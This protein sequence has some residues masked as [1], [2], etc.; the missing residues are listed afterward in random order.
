MAFGLL[1]SAVMNICFGM[2]GSFILLIL[3]WT[4]NG[5]FQGIG[6][7]PCGRS[8]AH[9]YTS[10]ERGVKTSIWNSSTSIGAG[11]VAVLCGNLVEYGW[12]LCF[13]VPAA[14]AIV[15]AVFVWQRL[16]D[17]PQSLGLPSIEEYGREEPVPT[18]AAET[19]QV[20][21]ESA[22]S[23]RRFL[24]H[25]VFLNP[26]MWAVS[27]ANFFLYVVRYAI[28]DWSPTFLQEMRE[29]PIAKGGYWVAVGFEGA[30]VLGMLVGGWMCDR[31]F[32]GRAGRACFFAM[33]ICAL[34]ILLFWRLPAPYAQSIWANCLLAGGIGFFCYSAQM[35]VVVIA[36]NLGTKRAAATA[37]GLTGLFG[38]LSKVFS[39]AGL[40]WVVDHYGW[41]N[42]FPPLVA[43][44]TVSA[45][46]FAL[47]W[48]TTDERRLGKG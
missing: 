15:G 7:A 6:V 30:G 47:L 48:N 35:L 10:K 18:P 37:I 9:W 34:F 42:V 14:L 22:V 40:G 2:S 33:G 5:W 32:R 3:F 43:C 29:I 38:Y 24:L 45:L 28:L 39:G 11:L 20:Q 41:D 8:L 21:E 4:L 46:L 31:V 19:P 17:R 23:F 36:I 16:R 25:N 12:R 27:L 26:M 1:F 44:A 13:F